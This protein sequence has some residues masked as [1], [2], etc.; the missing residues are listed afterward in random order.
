[1]QARERNEPSWYAL[2]ADDDDD[3][4]SL[5]AAVLRNARMS[6]CE[7]ANGEELVECYRALKN[8]VAGR[9]VVVSDIEMPGMDGIEA[10]K[11][12][13]TLSRSTPIVLMTG[14]ANPHVADAAQDAGAN[15]VL[16]KPVKT[17]GL[18]RMVEDFRAHGA[19]RD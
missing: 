4:R 7:A 6:V 15:A 13:R 9:L 1:M 16:P 19:F 2:V 11:E 3:N 18:L 17:E 10:T 14:Y 12:L 5:M 8:S